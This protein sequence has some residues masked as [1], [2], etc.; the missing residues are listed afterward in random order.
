MP[1]CFALAELKRRS[2]WVGVSECRGNNYKTQ[3]LKTQ[4]Q[5][6]LSLSLNRFIFIYLRFLF[7][8]FYLFI[9]YFI[10]KLY[11]IVVC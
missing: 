2:A 10:Y 6:N 11:L 7:K 1:R 4:R 3:N 9:D 8:N 5:N